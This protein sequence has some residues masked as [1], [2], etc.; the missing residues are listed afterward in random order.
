MLYDLGPRLAS[1]RRKKNLTQQELVSRAK[2]RDPHLRPTDSALG[3]YENDQS[4]PRLAEAAALADV[5]GVLL[6]YLASGEACETLP[7]KGLTGEQAAL[8]ADMIAMLHR[9]NTGECQADAERKLS[10]EQAM[11]LARIIAQFVR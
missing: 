8:I 4:V 9:M 2:A 7:A 10:P 1:L 5:L 3:K 6:D 11:L